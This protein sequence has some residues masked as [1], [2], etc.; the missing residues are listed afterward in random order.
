MP[1]E[2]CQFLWTTSVRCQDFEQSETL[3][4]APECQVWLERPARVE[5][6]LHLGTVTWLELQRDYG[7][8]RSAT[9]AGTGDAQLLSLVG[10][11]L[12]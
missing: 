10:H 11:L 1:L 8:G 2:L 4:A 5:P 3:L 12:E 6:H 7:D 9:A